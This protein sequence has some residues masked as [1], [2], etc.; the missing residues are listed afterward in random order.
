MT[1]EVPAAIGRSATQT[2]DVLVAA[3]LAPSVHNTQPWRFRL[4]SSGIE[5][6]AEPSRRLAVCDPLGEEQRL[7]CG[8]ALFN[9]RLALAGQGLHPVVSTTPDHSRPDLLAV[10]RGGTRRPA[11]PE[12]A[13]LLR[14]IPRR[15]TNRRPFADTSV[16]PPERHT[17]QHAAH[18]EGAQLHLVGD[19]RHAELS[20]LAA[21]AHQLQFADQAFRAELAAWTAH[22]GGRSDGVPAAAGGPLP[23]PH[24]RWVH[25]DFTG[26]QGRRRVGGKDFE[27]RPLIAVLTARGSGQAVDVRAGEALQRVLLTAT[28][29]GLAVSFVSQLVEVPDVRDQVQRMVGGIGVPRV[30][31]RIGRGWPVAATPRLPVED[32]V[33]GEPADRAAP[34]G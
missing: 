6:H 23:E 32:L 31:L 24:D 3:G 13:S 16:T 9:L 27:D 7:S 2:R 11:T 34:L 30:V 1:S 22:D 17:L 10:V 19:T 4:L 14:A 25:R 33:L 28:V 15:H 29:A 12:I 18:L 26:G 21:Q 5:L 8:A 20:D